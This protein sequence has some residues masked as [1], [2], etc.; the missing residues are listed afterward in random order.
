M[1][2]ILFLHNIRSAHNVGSIIRSA[3]GF[4]VSQI[5]YSGWTPV[6]ENACPE[7]LPHV[8]E[9]VTAQISKTAL[10]AEKLVPGFWTRD[11]DM[12]LVE[13]RAE[14]W[15]IVGLENNIKD[16]RLHALPEFRELG[17]GDRVAL[18]LGEETRGIPEELHDLIDVF[19]E[20]PMKGKKESYNVSVAAG[21]A[22][23][24]L[25]GRE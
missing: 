23:Y 21:I 5:I 20:I 17:L 18:V 7:A 24:E 25:L 4:G 1:N 13:L 22:L 10:G 11:I 12:G 19:L 8:T 16:E 9:K 2:L 14:G 15:K 6:P 3:E